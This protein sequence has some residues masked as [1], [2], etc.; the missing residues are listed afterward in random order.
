MKAAFATLFLRL[1]PATRWFPFKLFVLRIFGM[2]IGDNSRICS[3]VSYQGSGH[4]RIGSDCWIG[5]GVSFYSVED[6]SIEVGDRC[7]I[8]PRVILHCGTH[9]IGPHSR[10]AGQVTGENIVIGAGSWIGVGSIILPG[11]SLGEGTIVA[12]GAVVPRGVYPPN[13]LLGGVPAKL[14]RNLSS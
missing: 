1:M 2:D 11:V 14:I 7:D 4:V 5:L 8:A 6:T 10:R 9:E 3:G 12:S 13:V